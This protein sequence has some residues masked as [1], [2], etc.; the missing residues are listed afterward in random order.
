M[1]AGSSTRRASFAATTTSHCST[2]V[3]KPE[4]KTPD[5]FIHPLTDR[6]ASDS[7]LFLPT[8]IGE[9]RRHGRVTGSFWA[10]CRLT[11]RG[12]DSVTGDFRVF[13]DDGSLRLELRGL[14]ARLVEASA[15][16][17]STLDDCL[18]DY[19]WE[20]SLLDGSTAPLERRSILRETPDAVFEDLRAEADRLSVQ[21]GWRRYYD[22]GEADLLSLAA[23]HTMPV[24]YW[25]YPELSAAAHEDWSITPQAIDF[26]ARSFVEYLSKLSI[27]FAE[28]GQPLVL[29]QDF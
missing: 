3:K 26:Y 4:V 2:S 16:A 13:D 9:I 24:M 21:S 18:Y 1:E 23:H 20:P 12:N 8:S 27:D 7:R 6:Y 14:C 28:F 25:A 11:T 17:R 15:E 19:R 10:S 29:Q 22:R 5:R